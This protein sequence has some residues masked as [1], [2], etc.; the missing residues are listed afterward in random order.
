M[1]KSLAD[2]FG[3]VNLANHSF[4]LRNHE[5]ELKIVQAKNELKPFYLN[6]ENIFKDSHIITS[7]TQHDLKNIKI[8]EA[9]K[10]IKNIFNYAN[11]ILHKNHCGFEKVNN[12]FND[13]LQVKKQMKTSNSL[14]EVITLCNKYLMSNA[15]KSQGIV[16]I[17][18]SYFEKKLEICAL[19]KKLE[20][21]K[22]K[23]KK[24]DE[25]F[26]VFRDDLFIKNNEGSYDIA[27]LPLEHI[28]PFALPNIKI[29]NFSFDTLLMC[30][31]AV[32]HRLSSLYSKN[33]IK[34][35]SMLKDKEIIIQR[36]RSRLEI[37]YFDLVDT[38]RFRISYISLDEKIRESENKKWAL[39]LVKTQIEFLS[40][41]S[42]K[43]NLNHKVV[44]FQELWGSNI[45]FGLGK[46]D[47]VFLETS[48][49][50]ISLFREYITG[51]FESIFQ[52]RAKKI[53]ELMV[54]PQFK[55]YAKRF[56]DFNK[57]IVNFTNA[58]LC[59]KASEKLSGVNIYKQSLESTINQ[60]EN[61]KDKIINREA[62][63][64]RLNTLNRHCFDASLAQALVP[65][66]KMNECQKH[67]KQML[68]LVSC[69]STHSDFAI[70]K[71]VVFKY[72]ISLKENY[73]ES[74]KYLPIENLL[75]N[76]NQLQESLQ[77]HFNS[78]FGI[79]LAMRGSEQHDLDLADWKLLSQIE[80]TSLDFLIKMAKNQKQESLLTDH[81]FEYLFIHNIQDC[82][83]TYEDLYHKKITELEIKIKTDSAIALKEK[84]LT[85]HTYHI[86]SKI[87]INA[88][89]HKHC[90]HDTLKKHF[91]EAKEQHIFKNTFIMETL[92]FIDKVLAV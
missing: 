91:N 47:F 7:L 67:V 40:G 59:G 55:L 6:A 11:Q 48:F 88:I 53:T 68:Y 38:L 12:A 31:A 36:E 79:S 52:K 30:L 49:Y 1:N 22:T 84:E 25:E 4:Y 85:I 37:I 90:T 9:V 86:F 54:D 19:E 41:V 33:I 64:F 42:H 65:A 18:Y 77:T 16:N 82:L 73:N 75:D 28:L 39:L 44:D 5:L 21:E 76:V 78:D 63:L 92:D 35:K 83:K 81:H 46:C 32:T 8:I 57:T 24:S 71:Q 74:R 61:R 3:V 34:T 13:C 10:K 20:H 15:M 51:E 50:L 89:L 43:T 14:H 2:Y 62:L 70:L 17:F 23:N 60:I 87:V 66:Q 29:S 58:I 72:V 26:S 56:E 45:A 80:E 69:I 27:D